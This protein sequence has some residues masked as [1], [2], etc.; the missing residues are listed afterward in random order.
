VPDPDAPVPDRAGFAAPGRSRSVVVMPTVGRSVGFA[1]L[2]LT[3]VV[4]TSC[5]TSKDNDVARALT[6]QEFAFS[7]DPYRARAEAK[8][9]VLNLD[10]VKHT[11]TADDGSFATGAIGSGRRTSIT[12]DGPGTFAYHCDIH[13]AMRGVL[14]VAE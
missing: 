12:V 1:V 7:P 3:L 11:L 9:T 13:P 14:R 5:G 6:V 2:A 8:V 4:S 10:A